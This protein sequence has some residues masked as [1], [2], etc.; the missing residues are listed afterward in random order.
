MIAAETARHGTK[1]PSH[2]M[3]K[4][5]SKGESERAHVNAFAEL[6]CTIHREKTRRKDIQSIQLLRQIAHA[7]AHHPRV[8]QD[9]VLGGGDGDSDAEMIA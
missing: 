1:M 9:F 8:I 6:E 7:S 3:G 4:V 5:N 2:P